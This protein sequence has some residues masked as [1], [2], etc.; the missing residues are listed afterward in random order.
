MSTSEEAAATSG[1][2]T[3]VRIETPGAPPMWRRQTVVDGH[4]VY[5]ETRSAALAALWI[6]EL[7]P[8]RR[9]FR[10]ADLDLI[11]RLIESTGAL[12]L[13]RSLDELRL[14]TV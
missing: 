12:S 1:S 10:E 9:S 7:E 3:I 13:Q 4:Q 14:T 5:A 8:P 6:K 2:V 11:A